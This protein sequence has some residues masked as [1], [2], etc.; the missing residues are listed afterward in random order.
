MLRVQGIKI[1]N[2]KNVVSNEL[3]MPCLK[4]KVD[5]PKESKIYRTPQIRVKLTRFSPSQPV[6]GE[7]EYEVPSTEGNGDNSDGGKA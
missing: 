6:N 2:S 1:I 4:H 3:E 5:K 7:A